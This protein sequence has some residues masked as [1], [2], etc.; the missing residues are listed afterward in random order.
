MFPITAKKTYFTSHYRLSGQRLET[1]M[2]IRDLGVLFRH[3]LSFDRHI[4]TVIAKAYSMLG[5]LKR[6]CKNFWSLDALTSVY[7]AHVRSHLE[8]ACIVWYP[9]YAIYSNRLESIQKKFVLFALRHRYPRHDYLNL[10]SYQLR[11]DI[12][13]LNQLTIRR[14]MFCVMFVFDLFSN[15]VD[16]SN[17]ISMFNLAIPSR[18]L[19]YNFD[20]FNIPFRHTNFGLS[21]PLII[22]CSICNAIY[23]H[24]EHPIDFSHQRYQFKKNVIHALRSVE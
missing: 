8:Y 5:F 24:L 3:N 15:H 14:K 9:N 7:C 4:D 10:P 2:D 21:D 17:L 18:R 19:R 23:N 12:L 16:S 20:I 11:C 1:L 6:V 22:M 13:L